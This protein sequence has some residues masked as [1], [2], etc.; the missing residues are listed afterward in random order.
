MLLAFVVQPDVRQVQAYVVLNPSTPAIL[1]HRVL[2]LTAFLQTTQHVFAAF[3]RFLQ[4]QAYTV[5]YLPTP[6]ILTP[7]ALKLVA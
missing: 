3:H 6:V 1:G 4:I 2:K 5:R 7:P